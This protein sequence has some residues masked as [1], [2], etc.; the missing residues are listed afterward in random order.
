LDRGISIIAIG[1]E[2]LHGMTLN[3]NSTCIAD[4]LFQRGYL[5]VSHSVT[6]DSPEDIAHIIMQELRAQRDVIT[7]GGLGPTSDDNTKAVVA[8]LFSRPLVRDDILFK[9]LGRRYGEQFPT[10][11]HQSLQ[12]KGAIIFRNIV[13]TAPGLLLEDKQL[14]P[15][16]RLFILPG[17]P[18][19]MKDVFF[20]EVLPQFFPKKGTQCRVFR[21]L[22]LPEHKIDPF[23]RLLQERHP[24]LHVGIYPSYQIVCVH[25]S[26]LDPNDAPVLENAAVALQSA[27]QQYLL[28]ESGTTLEGAVHT[29]LRERGW[30][31][32]MAE[33][34]T[35]GAVAARLTSLPGSS[36]VVCGAVVAY[37]NGVK[38]SLLAVPGDVLQQHGAVSTEVTEYMA[39]GAK[40]LFR[41][42]VVCAVSGFFGPDGGTQ[43]APVGTVCASFLTPNN[44][45]SERFFF[46]GTRES[47]CER[48]IQTL[49]ARLIMLLRVEQTP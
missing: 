25:L 37:Q 47:I 38:E 34:C 11:E 16:A 31:I 3:T 26:V 29:L 22:S 35:G 15:G 41:V 9:E 39:R 40:G 27:F 44:V 46:H 4:A 24:Q 8:Q 48:T 33:W 43:E 30:K 2:V 18:H 32:A 19:E 10:L 5:P 28:L 1:D 13:G 12:P 14:F 6:S 21:F 23:L 20:S 42:E 49:L 17:P 45:V 7:T 36:D